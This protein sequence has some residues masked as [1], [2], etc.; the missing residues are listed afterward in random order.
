MYCSLP[1]IEELLLAN[2]QAHFRYFHLL[3]DDHADLIFAMTD[4]IAKRART[5]GGTTVR[6]IEHICRLQR[7]ADRKKT[8]LREYQDRTM[9]IA[10]SRKRTT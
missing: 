1:E 3:L 8:A 7:L 2:I 9:L 10:Y 5:I 6:L 4:E